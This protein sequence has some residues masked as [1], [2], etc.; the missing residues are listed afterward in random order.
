MKIFNRKFS[1]REVNLFKGGS[2][3]L[4]FTHNFFFL[5]FGQLTSGQRTSSLHSCFFLFPDESFLSCDPFDTFVF[6]TPRKLKFLRVSP[7]LLYLPFNILFNI[8][9]PRGP[10]SLLLKKYYSA[11]RGVSRMTSTSTEMGGLLRGNISF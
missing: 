7:I 9:E 6:L 10:N 8:L 4:C 2:F 11:F 5:R 3:Y 1:L